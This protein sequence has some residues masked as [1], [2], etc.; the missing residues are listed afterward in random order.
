MCYQGNRAAINERKVG[1]IILIKT[2]NKKNITLLEQSQNLISNMTADFQS[3]WG[4]KLQYIVVKRIR[5]SCLNV[6]LNQGLSFSRTIISLVGIQSL[7]ITK[8][9]VVNSLHISSTSSIFHILSF[10]SISFIFLSNFSMS[11]LSYCQ[12]SLLNVVEIPLG[13]SIYATAAS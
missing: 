6:L 1:S 7:A 8:N 10:Q 2:K 3:T 13:Q 12:I 9:V 4:T 5:I 11:I